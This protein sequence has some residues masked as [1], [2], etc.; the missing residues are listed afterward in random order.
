MEAVEDRRKRLKAISSSANDTS[1]ASDAPKG[2]LIN[3]LAD[4]KTKNPASSSAGFSFYRSAWYSQLLL[5]TRLYSSS[6][7]D[8]TLIPKLHSN[9]L[10]ASSSSRP[11]LHQHLPLP[12]ACLATSPWPPPPGMAQPR[13]PPPTTQPQPPPP[14]GMAQP[15][16]AFRPHQVVPGTAWRPGLPGPQVYG[17]PP[18]GAPPRPPLGQ[19]QPPPPQ[20]Q[21]NWRERG[22][23]RGRGRGGG[24]RG[25]GGRNGPAHSGMVLC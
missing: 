13:P 24:G 21:Q 18:P 14:P 22:P 4:V 15:V 1:D 6:L 23:G 3:P 9:P 11:V 5:L 12:P 10:G 2:P 19:P 25:R 20:H 17:T 7:S 16:P 8:T